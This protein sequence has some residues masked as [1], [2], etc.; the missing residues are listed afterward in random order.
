MSS[1][2]IVT[3]SYKTYR[4]T[5]QISHYVSFVEK[6]YHYTL[7]EC[8]VNKFQNRKQKLKTDYQSFWLCARKTIFLIFEVFLYFDIFDK[9]VLYLNWKCTLATNM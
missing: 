3:V 9:S 1:E 5:Y 6:V 4:D 7:V 8:I 2:G